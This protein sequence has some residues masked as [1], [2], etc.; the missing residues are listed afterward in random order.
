M[1]KVKN[2]MATRCELALMGKVVEVHS[3]DEVQA[4]TEYIFSAMGKDPNK[5]VDILENAIQRYNKNEVKYLVCNTVMDMPCI[6]YLLASPEDADEE[7]KYPAPFE[8]DYGTG[9][10]ASFC[11]VFNTDNDWCSE[12]GDC[13]FEKRSD[14]YYHR[15]SQ[16]T[17]PTLLASV[18]SGQAYIQHYK[19]RGGNQDED[20][21]KNN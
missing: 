6:T 14:G 8:E 5:L 10:P 18:V 17:T 19:I 7:D 13:F 15:I 16:D 21:N 1:S 4:M 11:Y 3:N 20:Y 9:K 12:F 2:E